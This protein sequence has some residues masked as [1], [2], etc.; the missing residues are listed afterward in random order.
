MDRLLTHLVRLQE[1]LSA[2]L[3]VLRDEQQQ[4]S[5]GAVDGVALQALTEQ[6]NALLGCI[7]HLEYTRL[8]L[9][10]DLG[11]AAPYAQWPA[12]AQR[13]QYIHTASAELSQLNRHNGLLLLEHQRLNSAA[14]AL[15]QGSQGQML[16]GPDGQSKSRGR[17]GRKI[18]V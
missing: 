5:S 6:K 17:R 2:L 13:W 10:Q 4:L 3:I 8:R 15:L 12:L 9:E 7:R 14:L 1:T 18:G 16:Y 11:D